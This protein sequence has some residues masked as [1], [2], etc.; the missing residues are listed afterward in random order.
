MNFKNY[1][2]SLLGLPAGSDI[3]TKQAARI[4][5]I[6]L[7]GDLY[8]SLEGSQYFTN[9]VNIKC[10]CP[11]VTEINLS[12]CNKIQQLT[13]SAFEG[14]KKLENITLPNKLTSIGVNA[15]YQCY[16]LK[17]ITI[18]NSVTSLGGSAFCACTSLQKINIPDGV[19]K[20]AGWTF[21]GCEELQSITLS[22]NITEIGAMTFNYC[23]KLTEIKLPTSL[24]TISGG[25]FCD[26]SGLTEL[27]LPENVSQIADY[28]FS[29]CVGVKYVYCKATTPPVIP[30]SIG[31]TPFF[32]CTA[33]T[34]I[35]VPET[36]V[37]AYK[38][39]DGWKNYATIIQ[40]Y[41]F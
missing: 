8:V 26:C 2:D 37:N 23:K 19:T 29:R 12:K 36:A 6:N 10:N 27:T 3:A 13:E 40:G 9:L 14:C 4:T 7:S 20:L 5:D 34:T 41:K 18:P 39:A 11:N 22:N 28:A 1:I 15:F 21:N 24:N 33:L 16:A 25:A 32:E 31:L 17:E 38:A 30:A 35:Y